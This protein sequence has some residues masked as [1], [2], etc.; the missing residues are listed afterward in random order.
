MEA[1]DE[2]AAFDTL[3]DM[4]MK[5]ETKRDFRVDF[6]N[7]EHRFNS[8]NTEV[9]TW[10]RR[11]NQILLDHPSVIRMHGQLGDKPPSGRGT[12]EEEFEII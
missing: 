3:K 11:L 12:F 6:M 2:C 10:G 5:G 1:A 7:A 4:R 9:I 8:L